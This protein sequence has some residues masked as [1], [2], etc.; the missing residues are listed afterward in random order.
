MNPF[1]LDQKTVFVSGASSGIGRAIALQVAQLG[2][3]VV[4]NGRDITR[5]TETIKSLTGSGHQ[6]LPGDLT[7]EGSASELAVKLPP[8]DGVVHCAGVYKL[9]P[10]RMISSREMREL[11]QVNFEAP[12]L[13]TQQ[14][15]KRKLI[16]PGGSIVFVSSISGSSVGTRANALYAASKA[17]LIGACRALALEVAP[18][19]I[20]ANCLAPGMVETDIVLRNKNLLDPGVIEEDRKKY[21]LGYGQPSDVAATVAFLPA[22]ASRWITGTCPIVDG[23]FTSQ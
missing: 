13:I 6:A 15:L 21:P 11:L 17:A 23:G 2:A 1:S 19:R 20:R 18:L 9:V 14:M 5:L 16:K 8:L 10:F 7:S 4:A 22:D 3:A 12:V